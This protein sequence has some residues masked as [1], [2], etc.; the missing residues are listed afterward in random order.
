[1]R[2]RIARLGV[3]RYQSE[4]IAKPKRGKCAGADYGF[5]TADGVE[6]DVFIH[7][8]SV[9]RAGIRDLSEGD[10]IVALVTPTARGMAVRTIYPDA[11]S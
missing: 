4:W 7:A 3:P 8:E 6:G 2:G 1:M 11:V 10:V 5:G 9:K